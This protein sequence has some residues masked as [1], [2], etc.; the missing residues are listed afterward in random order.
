MEA[1]KQGVR[2]RVGLGVQSL[3]RMPVPR[4]E[5]FQPNNIAVIC[6]ADN[7]RSAYTRF[8]K[9]DAAQDQRAH[10]ALT[11]LGLLHQ[12]VQKPV[13]RND[14]R[15]DPA[16]GLAVN[17]GRAAGELG[18]LAQERARTVRDNRWVVRQ[19]VALGD[20]D[21]AGQNDKH[22]R[23][24]LA[25]RRQALARAVEPRLAE[26]A[27][28]IDLCRLQ[29]RKHLVVPSL[30]DR[31]FR[32]RHGR[33]LDRRNGVAWSTS[34]TRRVARLH[35]GRTATG[36]ALAATK[37]VLSGGVGRMLALARSNLRNI[38]GAVLR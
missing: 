21:V 3:V 23:T 34:R 35:L 9:T 2:A 37:V 18:K 8:E 38:P 27:Y 14:Q 6:T 16:L 15:F 20:D 12:N 25:G 26:P 24:D 4:E 36:F 32:C 1:L 17:Q 7:H 31:A 5:S 22:T 30:D 11:Q 33:P 29:H 10:D 13:R 28:P 19:L